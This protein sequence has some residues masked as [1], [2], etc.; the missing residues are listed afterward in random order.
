MQEI[1]HTIMRNKSRSLLTAFG[2]FWGI[3]MLIVIAGCGLGIERKMHGA[4]GNL[5][6]NSAFFF[7][8][9]TTEP[10]KGFAR[11]REFNFHLSDVEA[12]RRRFPQVENISPV[13]WGGNVKLVHDDKSSDSYSAMGMSQDY[14]RI[15]PCQIV[16]GRFLNPIDESQERKVCL[17]GAEVANS[18]FRPGEQVIGSMVWINGA[19]YQVV[20][21]ISKL[22]D[23]NFACD[24]DKTIYIPYT[25][26]L[27]VQNKGE[28]IPAMVLSADKSVSIVDLEEDI[29]S[30]LRELCVIS[31][32]DESAIQGFDAKTIFDSYNG[33]F[34]GL[35]I[36]VWIVGIG[37]LLAGM[38]GVSNI[39]L[40]TVRERTQEIGVRR[41]LGATPIVIIRQIML[42]SMTLGLMA[43][44]AGIMAGVGVLSLLEMVLCAN[45]D[46]SVM[47]SP[48]VSFGVAMAATLILVAFSLLAGLLP[49]RRALRIKAIDAL[50]DE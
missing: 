49:S 16:E 37:T 41:A 29:K 48:Q 24:P 35:N 17:L 44:L 27:K 8:G 5:A 33:L 18:V 38:V 28:S 20:G 26:L 39:M 25:T 9:K 45:P 36:L 42:E 22:T 23:V 7:S 12:I 3:F 30:Y 14:N 34:M 46:E 31:P 32:T 47:G 2:V 10:Y 6:Q 13:V 19:A 11:G 21:K 15:N 1:W 40:V 50:R 4:F 43:G